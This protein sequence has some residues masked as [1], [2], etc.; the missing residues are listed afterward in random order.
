LWNRLWKK[1]GG[2]WENNE[3]YSK[4]RK[5]WS[6][7]AWI[8]EHIRRHGYDAMG[9]KTYKY[10]DSD[11]VV[12]FNPSYATPVSAHI[13]K[14]T[15]DADGIMNWKGLVSN[16]LSMEQLVWLKDYDEKNGIFKGDWEKDIPP[17]WKP[18]WRNW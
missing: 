7:F 8:R 14:T 4:Y 6:N 2:L 10:W 11:Q 12:V 1:E 16:A 17:C 13:T 15:D 9:D 18:E 3:R 5:I